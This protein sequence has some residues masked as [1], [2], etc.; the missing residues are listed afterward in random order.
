MWVLRM[1][2]EF[3]RYVN[4]VLVGDRWTR[5]SVM[6][7]DP[8]RETFP[9][10]RDNIGNRV[11]VLMIPGNPDNDGFYADFGQKLLRCL[12]SRNER[13]GFPERRYLFYAVSH[14]N[15][16][17]LPD[18]L[19]CSGKHRHCDRFKL[20]D[21]VQHKYDFA[22]EHLPR[23]QKASV[24]GHSIGACMMLRLLPYMKDDFNVKNAMGLFPTVEKMAVSEC[25]P[26]DLIT[27]AAELLNVNIFRN[28]IHLAHDESCKVRTF[29]QMSEIAIYELLLIHNVFWVTVF[30]NSLILCKTL[31]CFYYGV[32]DEWCPKEFGLF[33]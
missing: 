14:L 10:M 2:C 8:S 19:R 5:V 24:L 11:V 1:P 20:D 25:R 28:I 3:S 16:V 17:V 29:S 26:N 23:T 7:T 33:C 31:L 6:G 27:S 9:E 15:P 18:E 4:W 22:R 30:D 13:V 32:V 12:L 21:Q